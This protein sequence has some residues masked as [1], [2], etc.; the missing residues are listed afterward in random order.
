MQTLGLALHKKADFSIYGDAIIILGQ[1]VIVIFLI[2]QY[3]KSISAAEKMAATAILVAYCTV[4]VQDTML[5]E[6][7]W[8]F[9]QFSACALPFFS[10]GPQ[11]ITNFSNSSTGAL[12]F[13]TMFLGWAGSMSR[14]F[15]VI[16]ESDDFWFRMQFIL[17]CI[18]NSIIMLQFWLFWDAGKDKKVGKV[19]KKSPKDDTKSPKGKKVSQKA[20]SKKDQ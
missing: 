12:S 11:I 18:F 2:W 3:N 14:L 15:T 4:L 5:T 6:Q 19:D 8:E 20:E 10:R 16:V 7:M 13:A 9:V 1:N 17:A